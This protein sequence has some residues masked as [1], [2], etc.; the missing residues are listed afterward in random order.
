MFKSKPIVRIF[1]WKRNLSIKLEKKNCLGKLLPGFTCFSFE[2]ER[3]HRGSR[4]KPAALVLTRF[5]LREREKTRFSARDWNLL[6][7]IASLTG[8]HVFCR[9]SNKLFYRKILTL[10]PNSTTERYFFKGTRFLFKINRIVNHEK[11]PVMLVYISSQ[12]PLR[13]TKL[14]FY[15]LP[16]H[17][18]A[19]VKKISDN[20]VYKKRA[21]QTMEPIRWVLYGTLIWLIK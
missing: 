3:L 19:G 2:T 7:L 12:L 15:I 6:F 14:T 1:L 20:W 21:L 16:C 10:R 9:N 4:V 11:H 18:T 17:Q 5:L 8:S 13:L